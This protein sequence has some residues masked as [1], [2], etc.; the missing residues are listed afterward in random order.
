MG[1]LGYSPLPINL[2]QASFDQI[3]K[4]RDADSGVVIA[5]ASTSASP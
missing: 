4:L 2:V 5:Q 3:V 1:P